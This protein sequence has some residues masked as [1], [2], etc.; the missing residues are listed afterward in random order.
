[1][2]EPRWIPTR[3]GILNVWRYYDE[4]FEFHRGRLLLRGPNGSGKSKV[5]ELLLPFVLDGS[6]KSSR[7][8]TFGGTER[9]MHWNLMGDGATGTTRAGYVW[10]E[11]EHTDGRL[12]TC[13]A[14]LQ[15]T[16]HTT[17]VTPAYFAT[18]LKIGEGLS[19]TTETGQP[20]TR[21]Q[22]ESALGAHGI[23]YSSADDYRTHVRKTLYRGLSEAR[24]ESLLAALRQLR[25]P[26]LSERLDPGLLSDL[27]SSALPP[28]GEE[29]IREIAEGFERLD[30]QRTELRAL[31]E[32]VE[33]AARLAARQKT[34]ARRVL[35]ASA[36]ALIEAAG[37]VAGL[38]G[39]LKARR[40]ALRAAEEE[41][42]EVAA[43]HT[44]TE[45]LVRRLEARVEGLK[46]SE[47][48]RTGH[49]LS[50]LKDEAAEAELFA[51]EKRQR[52]EEAAR[53]AARREE[54]AERARRAL[55]EAESALARAEDDAA[56]MAQHSGLE[57]VYE[58]LRET[59]GVAQARTLLRAAISARAAQIREA[60]AQVRAHAH[61][62]R[63]RTE[64]EH[65][66]DDALERL[67]A[68]REAAALARTAR[69]EQ[70]EGLAS[71]YAA[72]AEK[73]TLLEP[74][75]SALAAAAEDAGAVEALIAE[76]RDRALD[77]AA[78][79]RLDALL[80]DLR[81]G[82]SSAVFSLA[83]EREACAGELA[84]LPDRKP[85]EEAVRELERAEH[86]LA[87]REDAV[88]ALQE[89]VKTCEKEVAAAFRRLGYVGAKLGLPTS[90]FELDLLD[91]ARN[92]A[93]ET[94]N[95]WLDAR[96][97][98]RI[99]AE[100]G[101]AA[102]E[103]AGAYLAL[104]RRAEAEAEEAAARAEALA[105]RRAAVDSALG[106][107][108]REI[109]QSIQEALEDR[110][111]GRVRLKTLAERRT[112]L[113]VSLGVLANETAAL[114]ARLAEAAGAR[115]R[116][117]ARFHRLTRGHLLADA[118]LD[119]APPG[120]DPVAA[121]AA[122][123]AVAERLPSTPYEPKHVREAEAAL[124]EAYHRARDCLQTRADLELAADDDVRILTA[125]VG[126]IR[127]GVAAFEQALRAERDER[128]ADLTE[129]EHELFDRTLAGDVRRHLAERIRQA[130]ELVEGMNERLRR[131]R[132]ASRV[133]VELV[134]QVDPRRAAGALEAGGLLL[135]EPGE[136]SERDRDVL[137]RFFRGLLDEARVGDTAASWEEQLLR[138]LDYTAWHQ[139]VVRLD[140]GDGRGLHELTR[141][142]HGAL[143]GGEKAI[144][145][146]LPLFAAVA[147]HYQADPGCPRFILL[148]EV[149]VGVDRANRGQVFQLLV[150]LGLDLV[151]T[152][153]HEWC[154]Y[155]EL[156]GIAI[157]VLQTG[158][159]D[160]A[161]TTTRFVW[162]GERTA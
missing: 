129:A 136:L 98:A 132:T 112:G 49:D 116:A 7:L 15:A 115:D 80:A 87:E 9:T 160:D 96:E 35:R 100:R 86:T 139:F 68:A 103:T 121:V 62:V 155:R 84:G 58:E 28:L 53:E 67:A 138:V 72:W 110:R 150:D 54:A 6:L 154:E 161:V 147:A 99:A 146:H 106:S 1:M 162:D 52:A 144:A 156:D 97:H 127:L 55:S 93:D 32:H 26:K 20:L 19:L 59:S 73:C 34:Y 117:V 158:D 105:E 85:F 111:A 122:A 141:K 109:L 118:R 124:Q 56:R 153:D 18:S 46:E 149:F 63:L 101:A 51:E 25:T 44:E 16:A 65:H 12:F 120:A 64:A 133:S 42:A 50:R 4:V 22:L 38:E 148:D 130:A 43:A 40:E 3:A 61:T 10:V 74:D 94:L 91:A 113:M 104:A 140:R 69:D 90:Q 24:Y 47:A 70:A 45:H 76:A 137:H 78:V 33:E 82:R 14:R 66:R 41:Q 27:L 159:G 13:G 31:D 60:G 23:V 11:F 36:Q 134:W 102:E 131:V 83:E 92:K 128:G 95:I 89:R 79:R 125:L 142:L 48:Y 108:Q 143:S 77:R 75:G 81:T 30:R 157:H 8:S 119:V 126:G 151:L 17:T 114:E 5:L 145:L 88:S 39:E 57:S 2:N 21:A 123:R 152:S 71:A 29:E 135:R 37:V 107:S